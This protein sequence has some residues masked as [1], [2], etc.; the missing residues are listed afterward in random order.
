MLIYSLYVIVISK[1]YLFRVKFVFLVS[2]LSLYVHH[3]C[4]SEIAECSPYT[5]AISNMTLV[6]VIVIEALQ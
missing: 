4:V 2:S 6:F 3:S 1:K 5:A